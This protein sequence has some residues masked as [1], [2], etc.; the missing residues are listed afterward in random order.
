MIGNAIPIPLVKAV[1]EP[2]INNLKSN[3][4]KI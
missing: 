4:E 1:C 2:I 3:W